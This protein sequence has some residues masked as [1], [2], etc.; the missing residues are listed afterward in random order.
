MAGDIDRTLAFMRACGFDVDGRAA[1]AARGTELY[2]SHEALV[3]EYEEA[4]TRREDAEISEL[5]DR[6]P[7]YDLSGHLVWIGE[8]TRQLDGAHVAFAASVANPVGIKLGPSA[9]PDDA[10]ALAN[11]VDPDH[12]P[13][14]LTFISRCGA[15]KV[16]DTLPQ[17]IEKVRA[18]GWLPVWSCDP[19]H[20]NT[21]ETAL[22]HKTRRFDDVVS[23]VR[24]FFAV[25]A[26]LGTHPG[27][28]HVELTGDDVTECTGGGESLR[29]DDLASRYETACDP[30]LN[31]G[32]SLELAFLVAEMLQQRRG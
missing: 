17:V 22:G 30:R 13:G 4:L 11:A 2:A 1:G 5:G 32:Q 28:L 16:A 23:E 21:V 3:L 18:E 25:H 10:V 7:R 27:G 8:R 9:T 31:A 24:E 14:R 19:M 26:S 12:V 29:D 15:G 6:A 20:G